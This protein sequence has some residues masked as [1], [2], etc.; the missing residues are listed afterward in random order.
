VT[1]EICAT[2]ATDKSA[3][4]REEAWKQY[5]R[6]Q[7]ARNETPL[8]AVYQMTREQ[9]MQA[10]PPG[11]LEYREALS[12]SGTYG[13][14]LREKNIAGEVAG[15]LFMHAGINPSRPAP[16]SIDEVN[17]RAR[18]EIRKVDNFRQRLVKQRMGVPSFTLQQVLDVAIW[19]LERASQAMTQAKAEGK[20]M[21]P[22]DLP[23]LR[24][25][26]EL[27]EIPK[28]SLIDPEGP[29]WFRGY[30]QWDEEKTAP[31]VTAFLDQMK[32]T[33]VLVGHTP[34]NDRKMHAR[35][36]GRVVVMDTGMLQAYFMGN[37]SALE[38]IG[39]TL[40]VL[41]PEGEETL[42]Q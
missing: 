1:P 35:Y 4:A 8:P 25:A 32:L 24:E 15:M 18:D 22:L 39:T 21:P 11:C 38:I 19:Q 9:W 3:D 40:K 13:K 30:A 41:Y 27:L 5:E 34:T 12:P 42:S 6:V 2:F 7:Q 29:L 26:Q 20:E 36:G 23:F 14:W 16:R 33:R 31:Q 37:P 28:W 10:Y 17:D